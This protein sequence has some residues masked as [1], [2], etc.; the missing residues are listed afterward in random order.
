MAHEITEHDRVGLAETGAWHKLGIV[1][2]ADMEPEEAFRQFLGWNVSKRPLFIQLEDGSYKQVDE[3]QA[4]VRDDIQTPLGVVGKD[5][6]PI[7]HKAILED[8]KALCGESGAKVHTIGSLR[9]GKRVWALLRL[10]ERALIK[11]DELQPYMAVMSSHDGSAAYTVSPT[12]VRIVCNNTFSAALDRSNASGKAFSIR[13]TKNAADLIQQARAA[14]G[15]VTTS[16]A[17][18]R[19]TLQTMADQ[20]VSDKFAQ[21]ALDKLY[22]NDTTQAENAKIEIY[23]AFKK[24]HGGMTRAVN[25]TAFGLYNA[26]TEYVDYMARTR[27]TEGK[28]AWQARAESSLIGRGASVRNDALKIIQECLKD[29]ECRALMDKGD[30]DTPVLDSILSAATN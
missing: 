8:I 23:R 1:V 21:F 5:Y 15:N 25:K 12:A 7:Q 10:Q 17:Q 26:V 6:E 14:I 27:T 2:P 3:W 22:P 20:E 24:P 29:K 30:G 18:F 9:G 4:T 28:S 19:D 13:H 11:G 16:W